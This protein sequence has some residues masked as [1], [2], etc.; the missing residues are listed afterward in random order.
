MELTFKNRKAVVTGAGRGI[1]KAIAQKLAAEGVHVICVSLSENSCG[2]TAEEIK[3]A[4]GSAQAFAVDVADKDAVAIASE[5]LLAEHEVIDIL[6]NNAGITKDNLILRMSDD[7]WQDV[8][9]TNLSSAFYWTKGLVRPMTRSRWGR[10]INISSVV[11]LMGNPG[12]ANYA[13]AKAG[14]L[15]YTKSLAR[16]FASRNV[17]ANAIAPGFIDTDMTS[18]LGDSVHEQILK[19]IPL[20]RLGHCDDIA[21]MVT[22][23]ASEQS[24]Y[25]T[26]Q[27]FTIDGGMVM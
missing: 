21:N 17:T 24:N 25:I 9:D 15:G 7:E 14:M 27:V 13:A 18:V 3:S 11:G 20:K 5:R 8:I 12:Q 19:M 4:G 10:I 6:V 23:L 1:G 2:S 16:E 26:G 22:Y